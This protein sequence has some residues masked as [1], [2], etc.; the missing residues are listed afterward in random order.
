MPISN[1]PEKY[2]KMYKSM[3]KEYGSKKGRKIFYMTLNKK[4][5]RSTPSGRIVKRKKKR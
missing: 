3:I 1:Y 4:G 2:Q 5:L